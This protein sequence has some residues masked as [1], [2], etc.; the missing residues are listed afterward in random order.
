MTT[1]TPS[2]PSLR[3]GLKTPPRAWTLTKPAT[4]VRFEPDHEDDAHHLHPKGAAE[5][6]KLSHKGH[7]DSYWP[8]TSWRGFYA[9]K[10]LSGRRVPPMAMAV[11]DPIPA[12]RN[13]RR[14]RLITG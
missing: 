8:E 7:H 5:R 10:T 14:D 2:Q 13:T 4:E 12:V 3:I 9:T 1:S 6:V 11:H